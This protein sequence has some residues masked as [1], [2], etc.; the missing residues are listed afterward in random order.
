M[1]CSTTMSTQ[2]ARADLSTSAGVS[3]ITPQPSAASVDSWS[4]AP[5]GGLTT[6]SGTTITRRPRASPRNVVSAWR[7]QRQ[8]ELGDFALLVV[9]EE[10]LADPDGADAS[11]V[12]RKQPEEYLGEE[13]RPRHDGIVLVPGLV[14]PPTPC[15]ARGGKF[16]THRGADVDPG[17]PGPRFPA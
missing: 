8:V 12:I 17:D 16:D 3:A 1:T 10:I 14:R 13:T 2:T 6:E 15:F 4:G 7:G 5:S 11:D 9:V